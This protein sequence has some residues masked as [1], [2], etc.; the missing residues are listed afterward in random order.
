MQVEQR[1]FWLLPRCLFQRHDSEPLEEAK[2]VFA[3]PLA[4]RDFLNNQRRDGR[5]Q[6]PAKDRCVGQSSD[7]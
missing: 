4:Q 6:M 1:Q 2:L 5:A 3:L 7:F